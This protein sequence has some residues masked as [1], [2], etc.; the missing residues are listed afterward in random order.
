MHKSNYVQENETHTT[1][2][3]FEIFFK[4]PN[5][6]QKTNLVIIKKKT[7]CYFLD[8]AVPVDLSENKRGQKK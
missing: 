7:T 4:L 6:N 3:E 5:L 8:F 1:P 2:C